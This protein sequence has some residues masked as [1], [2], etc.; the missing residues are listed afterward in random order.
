MTA[1]SRGDLPLEDYDHLTVGALAGR[2]RSLDAEQLAQVL[3]FE[4]AHG[5][6]MPVLQVLR[7][8][9]TALQA[10]AQP[11]GR[12]SRAVD[13]TE[14]DLTAAP[15]PAGG[16]SP[17]TTGDPVNPPSHGVPTNPAQPRG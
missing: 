7:R 4:E 3:A 13:V 6:R 5:R 1:I 16:V 12:G 2:I 17:A 11:T 10:G 15:A 8:R 9:M 14:A